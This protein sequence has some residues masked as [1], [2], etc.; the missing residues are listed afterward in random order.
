MRVLVGL[1]FGAILTP[2]TLRLLLP[3]VRLPDEVRPFESLL[4]G[5]TD[6]LAA[7]F[8]A[9]DAGGLLGGFLP[10]GGMGQLDA[11]IMAALIGW[12]VIQGVAM[13]VLALFQR[14]SNESD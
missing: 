9:F 1:M 4:I 8:H 7:P 12:S 2:L 3:F 6:L 10:P 14:R 13:T 5:W 11:G